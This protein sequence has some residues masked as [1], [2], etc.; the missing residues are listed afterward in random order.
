MKIIIPTSLFQEEFEEKINEI[1]TENITELDIYGCHK[2]TSIP[3]FPN[4]IKLECSI[5]RIKS[6]PFM[7]KLEEL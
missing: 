4:L 1:G 7:E 3:Y 6:I 5:T 2:I